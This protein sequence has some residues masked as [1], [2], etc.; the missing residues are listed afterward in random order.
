MAWRNDNQKREEF[1]KFKS[2]INLVEFIQNDDPEFKL[3]FS[4]ERAK[5]FVL[6]HSSGGSKISISNKNG[7]WMMR[8]FKTGSEGTIIDYLKDHRNMDWKEASDSLR[9]SLSSI[10][11]SPLYLN[12]S[13]I[14]ER[15]R[16]NTVKSWSFEKLNTTY[17][18]SRGISNET[19][20]SPTFLGKVGTKHY[21][22]NRGIQRF[23]T[24]FP[25]YKRLSDKIVGLEQSN[26]FYKGSFKDSQ[27]GLAFWKSNP[28][29]NN[30]TIMIG[31]NPIDLMAHYQLHNQGNKKNILYVGTLG[32]LSEKRLKAMEGYLAPREPRINKIILGFDNDLAGRRFALNT[33]GNLD[34]SRTNTDASFFLKV[35]IREGKGQKALLVVKANKK[36]TLEAIGNDLRQ[37]ANTLPLTSE[38]SLQYKGFQIRENNDNKRL[39]MFVSMNNRTKVI[40]PLVDYVKDFRK[41]P[42][43]I[44]RSIEKDF[45]KD[46]ENKLGIVRD[47]QKIGTNEITGKDIFKNVWKK[48]NNLNKGKSLDDGFSL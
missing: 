7:I 37:I 4:N 41:N 24:V 35:D 23:T 47:K 12:T 45:G 5:N 10:S 1:L 31:E 11:H 25:M 22:N 40:D 19:L 46:L 32:E 8:D 2:E 27:K 3:T 48:T 20:F 17:L 18:N 39:E 9:K 6:E 42:F 38:H 14:R 26:P 15:K 28:P 29:A 33:Y 13:P 36:E 43:E 44:E 16:P 30:P 34:L 21:L